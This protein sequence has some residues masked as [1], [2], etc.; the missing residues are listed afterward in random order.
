LTAVEPLRWRLLATRAGFVLAV[1]MRCIAP[2]HRSLR[3]RRPN[4]EL[5]GHEG[6]ADPRLLAAGCVCIQSLLPW[7]LPATLHA[8]VRSDCADSIARPVTLALCDGQGA[9]SIPSAPFSDPGFL[10]A[11]LPRSMLAIRSTLKFVRSFVWH[12]RGAV[13][14]RHVHHAADGHR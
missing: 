1:C 4:A 6:W 11:F 2:A 12:R 14:H 13:Q 8:C 9:S 10:S 7:W 5:R 3:A